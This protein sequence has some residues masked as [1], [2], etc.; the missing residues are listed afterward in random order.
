MSSAHLRQ[1]ENL[2]YEQTD[3]KNKSVMNI[4]TNKSNGSKKTNTDFFRYG[5]SNVRNKIHTMMSAA[6]PISQFVPFSGMFVSL[7]NKNLPWY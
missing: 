1:Q 2:K 5:S 6:D 7:S 3:F 4:N